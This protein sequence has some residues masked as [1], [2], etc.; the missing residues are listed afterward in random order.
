MAYLIDTN[1]LCE[2]SK[3]QPD[4]AVVQWLADH[5]AE[6]AISVLSLGEMLR[7]IYLMDRGKRREEIERW[8]R[9][10]ER[11]A[12]GRILPVDTAVTHTWALFCAKQQRT[13]R[14]L[15]AMDSLIAATAIEHH[16]TLVTRNLADFPA[17]LPVFNPWQ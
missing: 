13:G 2:S 16:L 1:V 7:G 9:R 3:P 6:L 10:I 8:Y 14:K 17:D 4:S 11:W 15:P 12:A 5:D